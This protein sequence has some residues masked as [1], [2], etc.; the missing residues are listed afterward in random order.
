MRLVAA[1]VPDGIGGLP[2]QD[3]LQRTVETDLPGP[4][5]Q[6]PSALVRL[7]GD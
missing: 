1:Y 4:R 7:E 2:A 6:A 5:A 3:A